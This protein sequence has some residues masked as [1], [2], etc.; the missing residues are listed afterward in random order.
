MGDPRPP[1]IR[2]R[3]RPVDR[4]P[5]PT[6]RGGNPAMRAGAEHR[7]WTRREFWLG[8][9]LVAFVCVGLTR[10]PLWQPGTLFGFDH[11]VQIGEAQ[12]WWNGRLDLPERRWDTALSDGRVYSYFPPMFSFVSAVVVPLFGGVPHPVIVLLCAAVPALAYPLFARLCGHPLPGALL[13]IGYVC[14]TSMLPVMEAALRGAAP[15]PVNHVLCSIGGLILAGEVLGRRRMWLAGIGL[16]LAA[17]SRQLT[18]VH[19]LPLA[20]AAWS[21]VP[22]PEGRRRLGVVGVTLVVIAGAYLGLNTLKYGDPLTTGYMLNHEGRDDVFAREAREHGLLSTWYVPRNLYYANVG[23]PRVQRI[24]VAGESRVYLRPN[25]MGTGVWWTTPLLLWLLADGGAILREGG[26][27][28]MLLLSSV[29]VFGLLM[30]WHATGA[31]QRG[32]N[33]YSLDCMGVLFALIAPRAFEGKRRWVTMA[34]LAWS[35]VYFR[36]VLPLPHVRIA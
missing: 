28:R 1:S 16:A 24:E 14:G 19:A 8:G 18:V 22:R 23:L 5:E 10:A 9:V 13:T 2:V 25:R 29:L 21:G 17:W 20:W 30:F 6:A 15:Y 35:V 4:Q 33:R 27:R 7:S 26:G 11:N 12:A 3:D 31:D 34:L 32:Y 36:F